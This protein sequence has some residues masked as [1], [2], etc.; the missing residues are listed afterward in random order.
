MSRDAVRVVIPLAAACRHLGAFALA[1]FW[2]A[3]LCVTRASAFEPSEPAP[4]AAHALLLD[5]AKIGHQLIAVG[6]H[7]DVVFS[8]DDGVTWT[9]VI[10]PTRALLTAVSFPDTT[11]GWIVGHDGVILATAD[12]G[13][14]WTRQD[15]GKDL[16]TVFLDVLFLNATHGFAVGAYG[17]FL[18][19]KDGGQTWTVRKPSAEEVHYNRLSA[20]AAGNLFLAGESGTLLISTD[21]GETW[22]KR[23][24]PYDGSLFGSLAVGKGATI[25]YGLRGHILRSID[26]GATW[27]PKN[28][29]TRVLISCGLRLKNDTI[30]LSGQGGNFF[31]SHDTGESFTVWKPDT[32]NTSVSA[33]VE[34]NDGA[35]VAVGEAGAVRIKLP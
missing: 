9:Q 17:N 12:G 26:D 1:A 14:T 4:L 11:H 20:D 7:G 28:S 34:G 8:R 18:V 22:L 21:G 32:F 10:V 30:V 19:T 2:V 13:V 3:G 6:D 35:L 15:S 29:D 16:D 25:V 23:N 5:V 31:I 24:V 27:E 33:M